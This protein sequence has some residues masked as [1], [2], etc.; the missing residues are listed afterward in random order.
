M[1]LARKRSFGVMSGN[2]ISSDMK[3]DPED[4]KVKERLGQKRQRLSLMLSK[5]MRNWIIQ[6]MESKGLCPVDLVQ[7]IRSELSQRTI[8]DILNPNSKR[9]RF[10]KKSLFLLVESIGI[11][12][13]S[14]MDRIASEKKTVAAAPGH[15]NRR[16]F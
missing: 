10:D 4:L 12:P 1:A 13:S 5:P 11:E 3:V 9:E 15:F 2:L 7:I 16:R 6:K 8:Y 14:F